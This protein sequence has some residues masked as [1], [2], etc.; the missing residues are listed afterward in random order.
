MSLILH[1]SW[2]ENAA[3]NVNPRGK[4]LPRDAV[5]YD[6]PYYAAV[7]PG[8]AATSALILPVNH[9]KGLDSAGQETGAEF[10]LY[11][12]IVVS[13]TILARLQNSGL[14]DESAPLYHN[15]HECSEKV[16]ALNETAHEEYLSRYSDGQYAAVT[17][18]KQEQ[19]A[20]AQRA[21]EMAAHP[22]AAAQ[23]PS[24]QKL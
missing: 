15:L 24:Y 7:L 12:Q 20:T 3:D 9:Y 17:Q 22:R 5:S 21:H 13:E 10:T 6:V 8:E 11:G 18:W 23:Q 2:R 4:P 1:E 14:I 19:G 16:R